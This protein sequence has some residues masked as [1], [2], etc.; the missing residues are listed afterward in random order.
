MDDLLISQ[1]LAA[2]LSSE[3]YAAFADLMKATPEKPP[4]IFAM[5]AGADTT[6][7]ML[8]I[9]GEFDTY[10]VRRKGTLTLMLHTRVGDETSS[11]DHEARFTALY[12]ALLATP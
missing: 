6:R 8:G 10:G 4:G 9:S 5:Q 1:E 11:V 3:A 7:P 12:S 2:V